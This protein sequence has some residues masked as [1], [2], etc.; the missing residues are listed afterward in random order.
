MILGNAAVDFAAAKK[1]HLATA[2]G[3]AITIEGGNITVTCPGT[4]T[5]QAGQKSFAGPGRVSAKLPA[6]PESKL[7]ETAIEF[8]L[9]L[10]DSPG[11][12]DE[13]LSQTPWIIAHS[14]GARDGADP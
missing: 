13:P 6:F 5:I 12:G 8:K 9:R 2:E 10:C 3:A 11:E 14:T 1:L 7:P 4:I